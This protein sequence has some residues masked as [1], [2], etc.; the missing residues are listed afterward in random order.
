VTTA[1]RGD[2]L[3]YLT[4]LS[5]PIERDI[6][7]TIDSSFRIAWVFDDREDYWSYR[8]FR[9][10]AGFGYAGDVDPSA[11][12]SERQTQIERIVFD[13]ANNLWPDQLTEPWPL[14][15]E[16]GDRGRPVRWCRSV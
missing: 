2:Q 16:H 3:A 9:S 5:A 4:S 15:P 7:A 12:E 8:C 13:V 10:E 6:R 11:T 14:C 1:S